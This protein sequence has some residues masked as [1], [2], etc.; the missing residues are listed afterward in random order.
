MVEML[1]SVRLPL[2]FG[3]LCFIYFLFVV[4]SYVLNF[5]GQGSKGLRKNLCGKISFA[6]G[7]S[8]QNLRIMALCDFQLNSS[9][10]CS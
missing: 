4:G 10:T 3:V 7:A 6:V 5:K 2:G 8:S 1:M 9:S